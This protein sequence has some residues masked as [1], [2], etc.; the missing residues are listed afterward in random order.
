MLLCLLF[1]TSNETT[2]YADY[3]NSMYEPGAEIPPNDYLVLG[4]DQADD[5]YETVL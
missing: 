1:S 4:D 2:S 5:S 3:E